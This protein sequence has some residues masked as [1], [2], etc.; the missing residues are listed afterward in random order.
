M[1]KLDLRRS[2]LYECAS[3]YSDERDQAAFLPMML[4]P[5]ASVPGDVEIRRHVEQLRL[6]R[7]L[8]DVLRWTLFNEEWLRKVR[9]EV[10]EVE[11]DSATFHTPK[12]LDYDAGINEDEREL[13]R[14]ALG[15]L[16][17]I[18]RTFLHD[19]RIAHRG[20]ELVRRMDTHGWTPESAFFVLGGFH[21]GVPP[22]F[23]TWD[24]LSGH[25]GPIEAEVL[26][27]RT[28]AARGASTARRL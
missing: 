23:T 6:Q 27:V 5:G 20:D 8:L 16:T 11:P 18:L 17:R 15:N 2:D 3:G 14:D 25:V 22:P 12:R 26:E 28:R 7:L 24:W 19:K 9:L 13:A 10:G 1:K 21:V 4:G